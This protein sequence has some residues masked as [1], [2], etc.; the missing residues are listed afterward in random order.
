MR[1][2]RF[3]LWCDT[4]SQD[5]SAAGFLAISSSSAYGRI[6]RRIPRAV[7][8]IHRFEGDHV[9]DAWE[10]EPRIYRG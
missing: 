9:P 3:V 10:L 6:G 5:S 2:S 4:I 1:P 8:M 7:V